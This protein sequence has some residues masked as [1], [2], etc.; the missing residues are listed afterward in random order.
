MSSATSTVG[1][2]ILTL[3]T[4]FVRF[5]LSHPISISF[6]LN[7]TCIRVKVFNDYQFV[8]IFIG[9]IIEAVTYSNFVRK[10]ILQ[11]LSNS[12]L[13]VSFEFFLCQCYLFYFTYFLI[14]LFIN[15]AIN[16]HQLTHNSFAQNIILLFCHL[17]IAPCLNQL[18]N[19]LSVLLY[20]LK[21]FCKKFHL[22]LRYKKIII[23]PKLL[24]NYSITKPT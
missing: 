22:K 19:F 10:F 11:F 8:F 2:I 7:F 24:H 23:L 15:Y 6:T 4:N 18:P 3:T 20:I 17:I 14:T 13:D 5:L 12:P 16:M 1:R 9:Y 21:H